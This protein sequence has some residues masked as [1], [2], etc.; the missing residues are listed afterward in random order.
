MKM[1]FLLL[2]WS[3]WFV[4]FSART[5]FSP[6]LPILEDEFAISHAL[7]GLILSFVSIG[8]TIAQFLS[9]LL[10][11]R[12]GYKPTIIVGFA[13]LTTA[14]FSLRYAHTYSSVV[15]V[16]LFIGF[17]GGIY[18]PSAIPLITRIFGR[19][20]WGKVI[21]FH[22][23]AASLSILVIPL[24]TALA[25][26]VLDWRSLFF[27]LSAVSLI[28]LSSFWALSPDPRPEEEQ[29][30]SLSHILRR[31][32]FWVLALLWIIAVSNGFGLY[33][34]IPLF[35]VKEKGMPFEFANTIFG[36]SRIGGVFSVAT[37]GFL[38]DRYG[39]KKIL[40]FLLLITGSS[41]IGLA[42][43]DIFPLMAAAL[44]VQATVSVAFFPVGQV[45]I[46]MLTSANERSTFMGT[47]I[48]IG[49]L[50][51]LGVTPALLGAVADV[52]SFQG[53]IFFLGVLTVLSCTLVTCLQK[54]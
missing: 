30:G 34:V 42:L 23:T 12:I 2:F 49:M 29:R 24:L 25:L 15:T 47:T 10:S 39:T 3:L 37:A 4:N 50:I 40:F 33:N 6:I 19:N 18:L 21:A 45:A 43:A 41:T 8:Y 51:G 20:H 48:A 22:G 53:G 26:R 27:I 1:L 46:S 16:S 11:P 28:V 17:G 14:L 5:V 52:W 35:L 44:F 36:L 9:G 7:A 38:V 54:I 31:G 13:I 32:D